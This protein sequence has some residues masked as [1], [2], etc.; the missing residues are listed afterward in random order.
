MSPRNAAL[1]QRLRQESHVAIQNAA[2][3]AFG[4]MGYHAASMAEIARRAGVSKALIYQHYA[5]KED[6]LREIVE[7]R[8]AVRARS[9]D[10]VPAHLS[11]RER[12][13]HVF[14]QAIERA[15]EDSDFQR[16]YLGLLLQPA[17]TAAVA[18]AAE[19]T[20]PVRATYY[21]AI[22]RAYT[23]MGWRDA[24]A[25]TLLFQMALNGLVQALLIQPAFTD[26]EQFP[27]SGV[28]EMLL[29]PPT[30]AERREARG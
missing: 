21:D 25:R 7:F 6:L 5:S 29:A 18:R 1:N 15:R 9:W 3:Q 19:V 28:R 8:T 14:D 23:E 30:E 17:V 20:R 16:L 2:L 4:E 12:L 10:E 11:A 24:G 13:G 27:L 22:E 26:S